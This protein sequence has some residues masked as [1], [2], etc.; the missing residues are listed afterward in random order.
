MN[1]YFAPGILYRYPIFILKKTH[2]ADI[3]IYIHLKR[4]VNEGRSYV[5]TGVKRIA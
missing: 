1:T 2:K 3:V 5:N 4:K